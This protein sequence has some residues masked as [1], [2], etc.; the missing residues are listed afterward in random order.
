MSK[1]SHLKFNFCLQN[2][3]ILS[4]FFDEQDR[5]RQECN[6]KMYQKT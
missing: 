4:Q 3:P 6:R 1:I 5:P 2:L